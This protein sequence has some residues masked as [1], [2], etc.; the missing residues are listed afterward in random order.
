[1]V[2]QD[3]IASEAL[4]LN[5]LPRTGPKYFNSNPL[6]PCS[7][8]K[9]QNITYLRDQRILRFFWNW[10]DIL[11][12]MFRGVLSQEWESLN[13]TDRAKTVKQK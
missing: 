11:P 1:M 10:N 7:A 6:L 5:P 4:E 2:V 9:C 3:L 12:E 13:H 8:M